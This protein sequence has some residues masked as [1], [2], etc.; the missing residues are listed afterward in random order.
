M[1]G[2]PLRLRLAPRCRDAGQGCRPAQLRR[3]TLGCA[4]SEQ[5]SGAGEGALTQHLERK[6]GFSRGEGSAGYRGSGGR[7][8]VLLGIGR[9]CEVRRVRV[10]VSSECG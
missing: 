5:V 3:V 10:A 7:Q 8:R 1:R 9:E 4:A 2:G 6:C